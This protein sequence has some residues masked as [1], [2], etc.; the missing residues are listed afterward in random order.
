[1]FMPCLGTTHT[2]K[3]DR[4]SLWVYRVCGTYLLTNFLKSRSRA[5]QHG[6]TAENLQGEHGPWALIAAGHVE[7]HRAVITLKRKDYTK[8]VVGRFGKGPVRL[9]LAM[10][11]FHRLM[12]T[13]ETLRTL[14][15]ARL[16]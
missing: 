10:C 8:V 1:M 16:S 4:D 13:T 14:F 15:R 9:A 6:V 7:K 5:V 2:R 3:I 11:G 12:M